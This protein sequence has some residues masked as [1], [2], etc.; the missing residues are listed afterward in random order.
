MK[1]I[2]YLICFIALTACN[3]MKQ[4]TGSKPN[5]STYA[6]TIGRGTGKGDSVLINGDIKVMDTDSV[7]Y[8]AAIGLQVIKLD[9]SGYKGRIQP[10]EEG[11]FSFMVLPGRYYLFFGAVGFGKIKTAEFIVKEGQ[12]VLLDAVLRPEVEPICDYEIQTPYKTVPRRL[13]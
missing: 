5:G 8:R 10:D 11:R 3:P 4:I 13:P 12:S 9:T 7:D 6:L 2:N 1:R